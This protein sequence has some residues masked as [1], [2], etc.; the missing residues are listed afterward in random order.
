MGR[1]DAARTGTPRRPRRCGGP[2]AVDVFAHLCL[3]CG[4]S[5]RTR[6]IHAGGV[7]CRRCVLQVRE[8]LAAAARGARSMKIAVI[9]TTYNRPDA[10]DAVLDAYTVQSDLDFELLVADDGS[11]ARTRELTERFA[12]HAPFA[13]AHVWQEDEGFRAAAIRNKALARTQA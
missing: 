13:V 10:L 3:A 8:A 4:I 9:V 11:T 7:Q 2:R 6:G 12:Q 1:T 5:R